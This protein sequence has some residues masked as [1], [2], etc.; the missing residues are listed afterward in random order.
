MDFVADSLFDGRKIR[1]LTIVDKFSRQCLA[2]PKGQSLKGEDVVAMMQHLYQQVDGVP[3]RIQVDDGSESIS[4][5]LDRWAY[6]QHVT[7]N[8]SRPGKL[9]DNPYIE[10]FNGSFLGRVPER[11]LVSVT[12]RCAGENRALAS[13]V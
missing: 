13:G 4:K 7:L 8:F 3:K 12:A 5:A 6:D 10:L 2:I 11:A 9:T 1:A